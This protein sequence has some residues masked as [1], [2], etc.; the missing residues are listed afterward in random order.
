MGRIYSVAKMSLIWLGPIYRGHFVEAAADFV[1]LTSNAAADPPMGQRAYNA[2]SLRELTGDIL[3]HSSGL[4]SGC[5][6]RLVQPCLDSARV[7]VSRL[8]CLPYDFSLKFC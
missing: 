8:M 4:C 5:G 3:S 2:L 1:V 6:Q 7:L